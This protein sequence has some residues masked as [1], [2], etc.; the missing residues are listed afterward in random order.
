M[1][2]GNTAEDGTVP[3]KVRGRGTITGPGPVVAILLAA[4]ESITGVPCDGY[5]EAILA[6]KAGPVP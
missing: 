5:V 4:V 3:L 2:V 6:Q 1:D